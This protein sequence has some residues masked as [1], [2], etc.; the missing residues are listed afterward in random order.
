MESLPT[1]AIRRDVSAVDHA[2]HEVA[3]SGKRTAERPRQNSTLTILAWHN[4]TPTPFF[5]GGAPS[6]Q[7]QLRLARR[8]GTPVALAPAVAALREGRPLPRRAFAVTFDDGYRDNIDVAAPILGHLGIPA[9]FF[10]VPGYLDRAV[11][12]W[13]ETVAWAVRRS[14]LSVVEWD[15]G[16]LPV[17]RSDGWRATAEAICGDLKATSHD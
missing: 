3:D 8:L 13:W 6:F 2:A 14:P 7:R 12:C 5:Q 17:G 16:I 10:L 4:V 9:T 15:G 1:R 11:R